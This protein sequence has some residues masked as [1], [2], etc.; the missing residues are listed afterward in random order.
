MPWMRRA[1]RALIVE[2]SQRVNHRKFGIGGDGLILVLPSK[3][4]DFKMRMFNPDGSEAEMCGNGIRCFAKYVYDRKLLPEPQLKVETLAGV[5]AL[6]LLLRAGKVESVRVD[7]G[8]AA[9][10]ALGN[11]DAR[12]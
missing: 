10:A 3:I 2:I 7:M 5:K 8:P 1:G 11:P 12:R 6:K 4:A 9:P